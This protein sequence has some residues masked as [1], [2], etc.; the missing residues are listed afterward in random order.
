MVYNVSV[1]LHISRGRCRGFHNSGP[2][3]PASAN[4]FFPHLRAP[5][6]IFIGLHGFLLLRCLADP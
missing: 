6:T 1:K 2:S 4:C 3:G 5:F